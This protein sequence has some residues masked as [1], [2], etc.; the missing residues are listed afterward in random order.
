MAQ[1]S[2]DEAFEDNVVGPFLNLSQDFLGNSYDYWDEL[3][4]EPYNF[5][6][7]DGTALYYMPLAFDK[8]LRVYDLTNDKPITIITEEE[9]FD[10]NI[11]NIADATE[12]DV[13]KF[14]FREVVGVK[15]Q[16]ATTG[17]TLQVKSSNS[18]DANKIVRVE[19]YLDSSLT[20]V[21]YSDI[22]ISG[23][24]YVAGTT[25]FYKILNVSKSG[26]TV[27]YV[28]LADSSSNVLAELGQN[29]R[30]AR[31]K[32]FRLGL[33]PD[34]SVTSYRV[35]FKRRWR[36]MVSDYDYPFVDASGFLIYNAA[37]LAFETQKEGLE[38][39]TALRSRAM[40]EYKVLMQSVGN[41][42]GPDYQHKYTSPL[43]QAHRS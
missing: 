12:G 9:Y 32:A 5:T 16:V 33:I 31:Y 19:G 2:S 26:D 10:S 29:D 8:P 36:K 17:D 30:V 35:L 6:S 27:G 3:K 21:G 4:G 23:T 22:T 25:T 38:R 14:Y 13:T 15:R 24:N 28:T 39:A 41:K 11:A 20:I 34:D 43:L 40:D 18:S 42:L 37:S 7:V 1:K